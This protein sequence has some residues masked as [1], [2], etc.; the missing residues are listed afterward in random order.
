MPVDGHKDVNKTLWLVTVCAHRRYRATSRW[1]RGLSV[2]HTLL[3]CHNGHEPKNVMSFEWEHFFKKIL[4]QVEG[5]SWPVCINHM[6][7]LMIQG[8]F[9]PSQTWIIFH[10][11]TGAH[12]LILHAG[13]HVWKCMIKHHLRSWLSFCLLVIIGGLKSP[14]SRLWSEALS[15][16][17][18]T[19]KRLYTVTQKS[20]DN[21][22]HKQPN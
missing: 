21:K 14:S 11:N 2:S 12:T 16:A 10:L 6:D 8:C 22:A 18:H 3:Q 1:L 19:H 17:A 15:Q 5:K 4:M 20:V 7:K 9:L 13:S